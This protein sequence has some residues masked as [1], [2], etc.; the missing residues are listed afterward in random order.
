M[1]MPGSKLPQKKAPV[2]PILIVL[3]IA[4]ACGTGAYL[5][6]NMTVVVLICVATILGIPAIIAAYLRARERRESADLLLLRGHVLLGWPDPDL[7]QIVPS[8]YRGG[9]IGVPQRIDIVYNPLLDEDAPENIAEVMRQAKK[10]YKVPYRISKE[11]KNRIRLVAAPNS[12]A[13]R[14]RDEKIDRSKLIIAKTFGTSASTTVAT[15]PVTRTVGDKQITETRVTRITVKY[16]VAPKLSRSGVRAS[17]E[18]QISGVLEGRWRGFWDLPNDSFWIEPRPELPPVIENPSVAPA[19]VDPL[20]TYDDL[21]VPIGVDED[22]HTISWRPKHDAHVLTTGKTGRGK[23]VCLLG[24]TEYL[25]AHG[26]EIWGIDGK[27]FEMLGLRTWFNVRL[28]AGRVDHQAR[29]A[30]KVYQEMQRR[31]AAYENGEQRLEDFTPILFVIDEFK[32][33]RNAL[34]RWYRMVKPKGASTQPPVLDEISDIASLG[35]KMRIHIVVGLQRPDAEF[36]TGDMRDNFGF[37]ISWGRLSAEGAKMMWNNFVTGTTIPAQIRGRGIAYNKAGE[38]VEIQGYWTPDPYQT[39]PE[40][41]EVWVFE[42]DLQ[43]VKQMQPA[44]R[45][46]ELMKIVDPDDRFVDLDGDDKVDALNYNDY[47][48]TRIISAGDPSLVDTSV[49]ISRAIADQ[50]AEEKQ[51]SRVALLER[52][53]IEA[54]AEDPEISDEEEMFAGYSPAADA[55]PEELLTPG[56]DLA[57]Q[58]VLMLVE[59]DSDTWGLVEFVDD[60]STLDDEDDDS[61]TFSYR[62][63]RTGEPGSKTVPRGTSVITRTPID[64]EAR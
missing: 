34:L 35:R 24:I 56:G 6:G 45:I 38:P 29:V 14:E 3:L 28:I 17:I 47:M 36:M 7:R 16:E 2:A 18:S 44:E 26:W 62:D 40:R 8:R 11:S 42:N 64:P 15:T 23:T 43:L 52:I 53:Q 58:G 48:D 31:M 63:F 5:A 50:A 61:V 22:G 59:S 54:E 49:K 25:A 46:H 4:T 32:T 60:D 51:A 57:H 30:H 12:A 37:R 27:R 20:A 10:Q 19:T 21:A 33:F 39:D 13:D 9:W 41:P 1:L 55:F